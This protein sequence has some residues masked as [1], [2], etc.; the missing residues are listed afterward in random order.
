MTVIRSR[1]Y[2]KTLAGLSFLVACLL[3]FVGLLLSPTHDVEAGVA[4]TVAQFLTFT[5]TILGIDYKFNGNTSKHPA[6]NPQ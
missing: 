6:R 3:A 4:L 2:E 1:R 5:A